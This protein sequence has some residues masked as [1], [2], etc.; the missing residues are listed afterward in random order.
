MQISAHPQTSQKKEKKE[1]DLFRAFNLQL[2]TENYSRDR[3]H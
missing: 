3:D 2:F 1:L